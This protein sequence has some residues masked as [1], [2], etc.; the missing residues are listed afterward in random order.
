MNKD[1]RKFWGIQLTEGGGW[2]GKSGQV[3]GKFQVAEMAGDPLASALLTYWNTVFLT[4]LSP[5]DLGRLQ[6][7]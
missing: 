7:H 3:N 1:Q 5:H 6:D 2:C 4:V